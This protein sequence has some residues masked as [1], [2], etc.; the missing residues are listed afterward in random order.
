MAA[1]SDRPYLPAAG[2]DAFL[3]LYDPITRLFG[4]QKALRRL[5][6]QAELEPGHVVL[7]VGCGTGTLAV[8][9]ARTCPGVEMT[10][11]DPDPR[12]LA[13]ARRKADRAGVS[14]RFER[15]FGDAMPFADG[16]VDRVFS[17]MMF[18]HL[19]REDRSKV[20]AEV[21]RVLKPGGRL[22]FLDFAG[23]PHNVLAQLVHG[24][25]L[26]TAAHERLLR[27]MAE[28]GFSFARRTGQ[29]RTAFGPI[30]YY[31]AAR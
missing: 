23:A 27:R 22:E 7:D 24:Q 30:A 5:A 21:H 29:R 9:V 18:H 19:S 11:I 10:G 20:L 17:S 2:K 15:G 14:V 8:L 4:F 1:P 3:P 31:Q 26:D 25:Q 16:A 6:D 13:R 12:A 28:A